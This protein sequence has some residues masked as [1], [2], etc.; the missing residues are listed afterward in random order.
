MIWFLSYYPVPGNITES[1]AA[2]IGHFLEPIFAPI[3]FTWE[4]V[5][6]L[7]FGVAAKEVIVS[8]LSTLTLSAQA[9]VSA[10]AELMKSGLTQFNALA[11]LMFV[12]L[13]VPCLP[14]LIVLKN[15]TGK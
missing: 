5:T 7:I 8:T 3:G 11:F 9:G 4:M 14:M 10:A 12:L 15:E 2:K 1:F 13:Y 6:S